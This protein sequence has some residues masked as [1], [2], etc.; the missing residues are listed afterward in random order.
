MNFS[1]RKSTSELNDKTLKRNVV[2]GKF[3]TIKVYQF[4]VDVT[5]DDKSKVKFKL[6]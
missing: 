4:V 5:V 2:N 6:V 3:M 1:F